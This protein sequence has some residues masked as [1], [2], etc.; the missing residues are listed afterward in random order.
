MCQKEGQGY[1]MGALADRAPVLEAAVWCALM[2]KGSG[3]VA[4]NDRYRT[5]F[6]GIIWSRRPD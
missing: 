3:R 1:Q 2:V 5:V 4:V 6:V